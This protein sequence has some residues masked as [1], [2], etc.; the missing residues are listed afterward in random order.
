M[1]AAIVSAVNEKWEVKEVPNLEPG[2]NQVLKDPRQWPVL[3]RRSPDQ[4]GTAWRVQQQ[5][6]SLESRG[7]GSL[8]Q[9]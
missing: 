1:K 9:G 6:E 7:H 8:C 3:H 2:P 5:N 4:G